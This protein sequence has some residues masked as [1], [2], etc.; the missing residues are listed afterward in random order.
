M[1]KPSYKKKICNRCKQE[2]LPIGPN[3]W[4][5]MD[6]RVEGRKEHARFD[7]EKWL[8]DNAELIRLKERERNQKPERKAYIANWRNDHKDELLEKEREHYWKNLDTERKKSREY[9]RSHPE[10]AAL[11]RDKHRTDAVIAAKKWFMENPER[12]RVIGSRKVAKR[13]ALGFVPLNTFFINSEAH[14]INRSDVIYIPKEMHRSIS[15]NIWSGRGMDAI[16]RLAG[17]YLTED[18]T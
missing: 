4:Y 5:C 1:K 18:W 2:Y 13:R 12:A 17:A 14:H 8:I 6:C 9:A 11:R 15:H 10:L 16:N 7:K 3:Q